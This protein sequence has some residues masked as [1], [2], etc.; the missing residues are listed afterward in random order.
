MERLR[1]RVY[2]QYNV[3]SLNAIN[4]KR[5]FH[6]KQ[7]TS[8]FQGMDVKQIQ[9]SVL[10]SCLLGLLAPAGL[11]GALAHPLRLPGTSQINKN[12][13]RMCPPHTR[14]TASQGKHRPSAFL[15]QCANSWW[16]THKQGAAATKTGHCFVR[17][18]CRVQSYTC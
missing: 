2:A 3:P 10:I 15:A 1:K 4:E 7:T 8:Y 9:V 18:R 13:S 17:V 16:R 12:V 11:P 6:E 5:H 14:L